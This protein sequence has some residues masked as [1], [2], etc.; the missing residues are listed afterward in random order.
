M[1]KDFT[2]SDGGVVPAGNVICVPQQAMMRDARYFERPDEF[3][4]FRFVK[5][6]N[7]RGTTDEGAGNITDRDN[8]PTRKLTDM[9][10]NFYLWGAMKKPW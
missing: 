2:F 1:L 4:P 7:S 5:H 9:E 6:R 3:L 10:P 8:V